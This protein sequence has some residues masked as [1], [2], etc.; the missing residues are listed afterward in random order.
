MNLH[1]LEPELL[2]AG[3]TL[4]PLPDNDENDLMEITSLRLNHMTLNLPNQ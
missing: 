2:V 1:N 4:K 3:Q